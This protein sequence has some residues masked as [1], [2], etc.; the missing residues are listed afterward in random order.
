MRTPHLLRAL[1][2]GGIAGLIA[3]LFIAGQM[4]LYLSPNIDPLTALTGVLVAGLA[5]VEVRAALRPAPPSGVPG[6]PLSD[7]ALTLALVLLPIGLGLLITPRA[8]DSSALGGQDLSHVVLAYASPPGSSR[9]QSAA[10]GTEAPELFA[11]LRRAGTEGVGQQVRA[12][13]VVAHGQGLAPNEFVLLRY[14]IVHCVA[15]ARP[16]GVIVTGPQVAWQPDDWVEIDG[17]L[18]T[19]EQDGDYLVALRASRVTPIE[20]PP[21]PYLPPM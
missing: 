1:V 20:E 5:L 15:D 21:D 17:E 3:K 8:L 7:Q 6:P 19:R 13:G 9:V 10:R 2:L 11:Y 12:M 18:D 16:I 14:S 4:G